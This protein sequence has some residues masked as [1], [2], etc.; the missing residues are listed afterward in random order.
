ME[1]CRLPFT[2]LIGLSSQ[3]GYTEI[4]NKN[5]ID[6]N[7]ATNLF[8][9][10]IT[11]FQ[12]RDWWFDPSPYLLPPANQVCEGCVF[13][14]VC[15]SIHRGRGGI[16][17][18][19]AGGIPVRLAGLGGGGVSRP[20]PRGEVEG[21]GRG[22]LQAHTWGGF[23]GPHPGGVSRPIPRGVSP[24]PHPGG[25]YP[26][27]HWGRP[28][29]GQLLPWVVHILLDCILVRSLVLSSISRGFR[30]TKEKKDSR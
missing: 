29:H 24:G 12:C 9:R 5:K 26:S 11:N 20:T 15:H 27:M 7:M 21:S 16:P 30:Y 10:Y 4:S 19:I 23:P 28:P 3:R 18:C 13:T 25:V 6:A 2:L 8:W 22:G 1:I 14:R 17:A